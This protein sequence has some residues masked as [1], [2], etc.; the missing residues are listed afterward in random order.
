MLAS[1]DF[2]GK[3]TFA[4]SSSWVQ[5]DPASG[6]LSVGADAG[7]G[8]TQF[9]AY[10]TEDAFVLQGNNGLYVTSSAGSYTANAKRD[11]ALNQFMLVAGTGGAVYVRDLGVDGAGPQFDWNNEVEC[12]AR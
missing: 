5:I 2:Y 12:C 9:N 1:R 7:D 6:V 10:G 3:W 8:R 11:G 4:Q